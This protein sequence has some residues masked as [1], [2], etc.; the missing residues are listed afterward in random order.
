MLYH[1]VNIWVG[2]LLLVNNVS[3]TYL[4][5]LEEKKI[6]WNDTCFTYI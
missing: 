3:K 1:T 5:D 4:Y 6:A 2:I